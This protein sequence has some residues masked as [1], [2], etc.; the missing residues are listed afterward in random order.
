M[1]AAIAIPAAAI[2]MTKVALGLSG[3]VDSAVAAALLAEQGYE[4]IGVYCQMTDDTTEQQDAMRVAEHLGI[5][6]C[7]LDL[8]AAFKKHV[9]SNFVEEYKNGRTP[10]PCIVCNPL[11]KFKGLA[12]LNTD[13]IATG[14]YAGI[15][16]NE[17]YYQVTRSATKDQSYMLA[18]LPQ[19][20]LSKL[21]L[22]LCGRTKE[23]N[24]ALA[25]ALSL[26]VAQKKDSQDLCFCK[27]YID[28]LRSEGVVVE[29]GDFLMDGAVVGQ[30]K[31]TPCYTIGQ[32]KNLGIALGRP[33]FVT[34]ID[35]RQNTVTLSHADPHT[36]IATVTDLAWQT[37][38]R[39]AF[40]CTV[41][42][43]LAAPPVPAQVTTDGSTATITFASPVRAVTPGQTCVFYDGDA[44][45][46]AGFFA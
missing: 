34:Q 4:V 21:L 11:V 27:N 20:I 30:H 26:P 46:C 32:R 10:N 17:N 3:G 42:T 40:A 43:R 1:A 16:K 25:E 9:L 2:A 41:K 22:P 19:D 29:A 18:R 8:R 36:T 6:F 45:L 13:Y 24:R 14:H 37:A 31:G 23:D 44:V 28:F 5:P 15:I 35:A 38:P 33:A 7:A 12:S 39:A